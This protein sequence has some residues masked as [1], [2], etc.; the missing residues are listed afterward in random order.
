MRERKGGMMK[1]PLR[2]LGMP[3]EAD[4]FCLDDQAVGWR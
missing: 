1:P 2:C 3:D 4:F